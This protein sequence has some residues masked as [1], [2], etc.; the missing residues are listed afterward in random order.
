LKTPTLVGVKVNSDKG[1]TIAI[2]GIIIIHGKKGKVDLL[3]NLSALSD[4]ETTVRNSKPH[5]F[6]MFEH[7]F[8]INY[9]LKGET[10]SLGQVTIYSDS[11][12]IFRRMKLQVIILVTTVVITLL[13]FSI[14]LFWAVNRYMRKPLKILTNATSDISL[15]NLASFSVD[16][17]VK[18]HNEIKVLENAM[19]SMVTNLAETI[20]KWNETEKALRGSEELYRSLVENIN[21]GITLIDNDHTIVMAN[22]AQG[23]MFNKAASYFYGKKCFIEF[24]KR[25]QVCPHCPGV[26]AMNSGEPEET[27]TQGQRDDGSFFTVNIKAF[28]LQ[29]EDGERRGFIEVVED[30]TD[31]IKTEKELLKIEKLE[32][33]GI[34]AGGIAHDFNNILAAI[35]GNINLAL[36]DEDLKGD[37]K[38]LLSEAEKASLR[39]KDLTQQLLTFAKGGEP[40]KELSTLV[41]VIKDSADFVLHGDR[42]ACN[43]DIPEDLWLVDI[44]KGQVSQ[45][46]Q[47]IIINA[48]HAMPEG[49][50]INV[51]CENLSSV[52]TDAMPFARDGK[53]VKISIHD[54]GIGIPANVLE[55]IFD[56]YFSTKQE[57]SGLGLAISQSIINKHGGLI[58]VESSP[59][60]GTTFNIYIPASKK[61]IPHPQMISGEYKTSSEAKVLVMDDEEMVR[62]VAK[63]MLVKIR[64]NVT[65]AVDGYEAVKFYKHSMQTG[66]LFDLVIMDLTVPGGMG[67]KEAV[68]EILKLN[69]EAKVVVSSGYSNDPVMAN[70]KEYGFCSA[71]V[72]PFKLQE[73]SSVIR[74]ILG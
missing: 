22:A 21:F 2:G 4:Q 33:I 8:P 72:K 5:S 27:I 40:V 12:I 15:S 31:Q 59:G 60:E 70:F 55:K 11:S 41:D 69:S 28:S 74:Q 25:D 32:S 51:A 16:T 37:T 7:Q 56:P 29:T 58:S 35:L 6:E 61:T 45:V 38:K 73:L 36:F 13:S 49:G 48:S 53:F 54:S 10:R 46:V 23:R 20:S 64:H 3:I 24:E 26:I 43:Y 52:R 67:G 68:K 71:I 47:N 39:A 18:G 19:T 62:S 1:A 9:N 44:D 65:L 66:D 17:K 63:A 50:I 30:I 14:V 42:V 57:G 34:L